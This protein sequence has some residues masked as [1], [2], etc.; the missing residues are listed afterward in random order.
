MLEARQGWE[1]LCKFLD[2]EV[3]AEP[4]PSANDSQSYFNGQE[5]YV[6]L[7]YSGF[8]KKAAISSLAVVVGFVAWRIQF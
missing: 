7:V 5:E 2:K 1:P 8:F 6:W 4:Y 3:P